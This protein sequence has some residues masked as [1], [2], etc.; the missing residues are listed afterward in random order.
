M[1]I[2]WKAFAL[3]ASCLFSA[4]HA[5]AVNAT[6]SGSGS[7]NYL[8]IDNDVDNEYFITPSSLDPRYS[9]ANVWT[10][11]S[12]NQRSLGYLGYVGWAYANRYFDMWITDSPINTPFV[13][14]RCMNNGSTCPSTGFIS[15]D[16]TDGEGF[17]H[18]RSGSSVY[19]GSYGFA[20]LSQSAY[21]YFRNQTVGASDVLT[22]NLCYTNTEYDAAAGER[23]KDLPSGAN[24]RYY[25]L[26]LNKVG[27]LTLRSTGSLSEIWIASDGTPSVN[28]GNDLCQIGVANNTSGMICKMVS[29]SLQQSQRVT[30]SLDFRMVVDTAELGF[31][32]GISEIMYSGDGASW[33]RFGSSTAYSN[34]FTTSGEYVY[35][36]LSNAFFKKV[37]NSGKDLTNKDSLFTFYFNN[38]VTPESGYYQFTAS[39]QLNIIP[40]E[41]GISIVSSDRHSHPKNSGKIGDENPVEFEYTVTTSAS[42]QADSITAQVV[43]DSTTIA[44]IPYCL[45]TSTDGTLTVPVPAYLAYTTQAGVTVKKRNSCGENPIN[46]TDANWVQTAWNAAVDDGFFFTTTLKLLFP[47]NDSRSQFTTSGVDWMG[48]VSASGEVKVTATWIGVDR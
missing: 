18:A 8:F 9:G 27:H 20:S 38:S 16:V 14:I 23:C 25:T 2:N 7:N 43:G 30:A 3:A 26:T 41:Y 48:T 17:Y 5:L 28:S 36:F 47:M 44:G 45:F 21:E 32:P 4:N 35:V 10:R 34:V 46:M 15:P 12:T 13:G 29:Y 37:L 11:Y 40:K 19:N 1:S 42:R 24:W 39:S 6:N 22:L 33:T 31:T